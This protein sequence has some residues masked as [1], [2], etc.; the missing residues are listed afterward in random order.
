MTVVFD[1]EGVIHSYK[2]GWQ[3][4]ENIPDPPVDGIRE[5]MQEILDAGYELVIVSTRSATVGGQQAIIDWCSKW[6]IPYSRISAEKPP[7]LAYVDDRSITF[8]P[9][10][11]PNLPH[12]IKNFKP[13]WEDQK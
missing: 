13:W 9:E 1:F 6:G 5:A 10:T 12:T 2:S 4:V 11:L 3:G 7:A 8:S